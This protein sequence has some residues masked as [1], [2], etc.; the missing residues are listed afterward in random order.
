[1]AAWFNAAEV[2][3]LGEVLQTNERSARRLACLRR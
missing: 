1:M 2:T 3:V